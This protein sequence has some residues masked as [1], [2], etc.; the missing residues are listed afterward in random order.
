MAGPEQ[1]K[2]AALPIALGEELDPL[3][4]WLPDLNHTQLTRALLFLLDRLRMEVLSLENSLPW[5]TLCSLKELSTAYPREGF[6]R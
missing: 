3:L 5:E 6:P 1:G 2:L 4:I